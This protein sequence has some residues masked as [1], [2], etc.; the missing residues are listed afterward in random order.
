M[1]NN[2]L[3][4]YT[5]GISASIILGLISIGQA[6]ADSAQLTMMKDQIRQIE[7]MGGQV[8]QSMYDMVKQLEKMELK[9]GKKSGK[10]ANLSCSQ[11]ISGTWVSS[12]RDQTVILNS[13]GTG[14]FVQ[15]SVGGEAYTSRVKYN[16]SAS[17]RNITF[18]YTSDLEYTHQKTGKVT[19]KAKPASGTV[20]CSFAENVL[21]IGGVP[22][23]RQ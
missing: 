14:N 5:R 4:V 22:F 2:N 18:N 23:Y 11:D 20:A 17:G 21:N 3:F 8:P 7:Q 6:F 10:P 15:K 12:G 13:N 16:W 9:E 1:K 19:Y